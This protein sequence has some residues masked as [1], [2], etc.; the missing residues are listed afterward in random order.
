M[1][2]LAVVLAALAFATSSLPVA[3]DPVVP[4]AFA[5]VA[6]LLGDWS[7]DGTSDAGA[8]SGSDSFRL[9]LG[10]HAI[11]RRAHAVYPAANGAPETTYD[12][13][14]IVYPDPSLPAG[15]GADSFDSGGHT[16]RYGLVAGTAP[17]VAQ[18]LSL[19]TTS[20]P[21]FRLTYELHGAGVLDV[22]FELAPPGS[23]TFQTVA[24]GVDHRTS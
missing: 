17:N 23:A 6:F 24:H 5:P 14:M 18:F 8:G 10:G 4:I 21:T 11:V 3:A 13:L 19:G 9:E 2:V 15:L 1:R 16:I 20:R 22:R 12:G 7:G